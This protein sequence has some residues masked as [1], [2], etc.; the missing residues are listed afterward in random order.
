MDCGHQQQQ[1]QQQQQQTTRRT[2]RIPKPTERM[3]EF[4]ESLYGRSCRRVR[5]NLFH[6]TRED[7]NDDELSANQDENMNL[8]DATHH[9]ENSPVND[10]NSGEN[11]VLLP[12]NDVPSIEE[13]FAI[14]AAGEKP[15]LLLE[16]HPQVGP[17]LIG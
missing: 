7:D 14:C 17:I 11:V 4:R 12:D 2:T 8:P 9:D 15:P 13:C 16:E 6:N 1:Q 5:K 10:E 3:Q